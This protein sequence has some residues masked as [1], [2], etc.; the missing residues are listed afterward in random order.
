MHSE[1]VD[2]LIIEDKKL[3][4]DYIESIFDVA[5]FKIIKIF[6]GREGFEYLLQH[7]NQNLVVILS[8]FL[9]SMNGIELMR[10]VKKS[11]KDFGFI[12]LTA[13]KTVET[14]IEA[15]KSGA[16]DFLPKSAKLH[17]HLEAI[18]RK[19]YQI[20]KDKIE[21]IRIQN[22]LIENELRLKTIMH[23]V[24]TGILLIDSELHTIED[25]NPAAEILL[26]HK[27]KN[28]LHRHYHDFFFDAELD[29]VLLTAELEL[30][31]QHESTVKI[32]DKETIDIL[33]NVAPVFV[34][35]RKHY[36]ISFVD[37]S[38]QKYAQ[39]QLTLQNIEI[40]QKNE[41]IAAQRDEL[42]AHRNF[43]I[44]QRDKIN[45]QTKAITDSIHYARRIQR[46]MLPPDEYIK[47]ILPQHFIFYRPRDI[48]SGD[49]YW[50]TQK[51]NKIL[52]ACA[53]C[54]GHGVP[55]ALM[56]MLGASLL[57][58]IVNQC[59]K[60]MKPSDILNSLRNSIIKTL[61]QTGKRGEAADGMDISLCIIDYEEFTLQFAGANNSMYLLRPRNQNDDASDSLLVG[62]NETHKLIEIKADNMPIGIYRNIEKPFTNYEMPFF[63]GDALYFLT[64]GYAD[65]FGGDD[66]RKFLI[67]N[68]KQMLLEIQ[69]FSME[70]QREIIIKRHIQWK[71]TY[72]QLDDILVIGIKLTNNKI[73]LVKD[74]YQWND[75]VILIAEDEDDNFMYLEQ[76]LAPSQVTLMRA[77]NGKEAVD[78]CTMNEHIDVVLMDIRMPIMNG[79]Q[80]TQEIKS[81]RKN[82]PVVVLTA[83]TMSGEKE[84]S[85][86]SGCDD[87]ISKPI[88]SKELFVTLS[89]YI[90]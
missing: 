86:K 42:E 58:E 25:I 39:N 32:S 59:D 47:H 70:K 11:G 48:V 13:D 53:D 55:G 7:E 9:P 83:Y 88:T 15:M 89:K 90:D 33:E 4:A 87:Y 27:R 45:I 16:L 43:L 66:L 51:D 6:D 46:A 17:E 31:V 49:F 19:V 74:K 71:S 52:V 41:E 81:F 30:L 72:K 8:Y 75:K 21:R 22:D 35:K 79:Y 12:F 54:T 78:K 2:I 69:E 18:V 57:S 40:Q 64:D 10:E 77:T 36:L 26:G 24:H 28:V 63:E 44:K 65:Q 29:K 85:F 67:K 50:I 14:A 56:S 73:N 68:V 76:L 38:E 62:S 3:Q 80:A 5:E 34:A 23:S 61:R 60:S 82:L 20:Q 37:I 84:K 1:K